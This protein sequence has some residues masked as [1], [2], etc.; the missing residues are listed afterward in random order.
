MV[1]TVM[2]DDQEFIENPW[3]SDSHMS[4]AINNALHNTTLIKKKIAH[5]HVKYEGYFL[6]V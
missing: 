1:K 5:R 2:T 4:I 3:F 6:S